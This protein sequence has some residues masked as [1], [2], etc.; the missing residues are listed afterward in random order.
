MIDS[1]KPT[2][3]FQ[4]HMGIL[5]QSLP[6]TA[7]LFTADLR[8]L[9]KTDLL[10]VEHL[11]FLLARM[12]ADPELK[13]FIL[14]QLQKKSHIE[15]SISDE[16]KTLHLNIYKKHFS[17]ADFNEALLYMKIEDIT[18]L[19][20]M[21]SEL[22]NTRA[23]RL[24]QSKMLELAKIVGEISH[25]I[26]NPL[27][28]I[29]AKSSY[30]KTVLNPT[31][32]EELSQS[33]V[34]KVESALEKIVHHGERISKVIRALK[35]LSAAT[36]NAPYQL[37]NL[38]TL[39]DEALLLCSEKMKK[40][41]IELC[42]E[43]PDD[44]TASIYCKPEQI[45][46]VI[47]SLLHNACEALEHT[48]SPKITISLQHTES[49]TDL[50]VSDNGKGVPVE[51]ESQVFTPFFTTKARGEHAGLG[52]SIANQIIYN[53]QGTLSLDRKN[54]LTLFKIRLSHK[55]AA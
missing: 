25:E 21:E 11:Q 33:E 32:E 43:I 31:T 37:F 39:I 1:K 7:A 48:A 13:K 29:L 27:T 55:R 34:N 53:H 30:I 36:N 4:H 6:E 38:A 26:N 51:I 16:S 22:E 3:Q 2:S 35:H 54:D 19:V 17:W 28:V 8:F 47:L 44:T 15:L 10:A 41:R 46:Q 49:F 52:L 50:V 12:E 9:H 24:H 45:L 14:E 42:L 23:L 40:R 5:L 20:A 18:R